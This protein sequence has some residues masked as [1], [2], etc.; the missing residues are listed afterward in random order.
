[1]SKINPILIFILLFTGTLVNGQNTNGQIPDE[2]KQFSDSL[3][4]VNIGDGHFERTTFL[5]NQS[6]IA[7][8]LALALNNCNSTF[9]EKKRKNKSSIQPK[10][11]VLKYNLL[12]IDT[13]HYEFE[14]RISKDRELMERIQLPNCLNS[15]LCNIKIGNAEAI[16]LAINSGLQ[17]GYG[18]YNEGLT[19]DEPTGTFQWRIK[20]HLAKGPDRGERLYIDAITGERVTDK[21][22]QWLRQ[23]VN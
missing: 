6:M 18:I 8:D 20:N 5:C 22:S 7:L 3:I 23:V 14:V 15:D 2:I 12:L 4:L 19:F 16:D 13:S 11:F 17:K 1:M 10:Y 9:K 21:D